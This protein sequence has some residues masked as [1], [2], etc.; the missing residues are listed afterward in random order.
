MN[1]ANKKC[2]IL[3]IFTFFAG[4]LAYWKGMLFCTA[5][6]QRMQSKI[7]PEFRTP[8]NPAGWGAL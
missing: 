1:K 6:R 8:E 7:A 4:V 2:S 3:G 5:A